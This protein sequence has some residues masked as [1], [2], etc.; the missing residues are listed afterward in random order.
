M[1]QVSDYVIEHLG[2]NISSSTHN[3][4]YEVDGSNALAAI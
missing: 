1:T 3:C 2:L 4:G